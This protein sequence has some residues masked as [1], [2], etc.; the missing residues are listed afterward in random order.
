MAEILKKTIEINTGRHML[1]R[2]YGSPF[3]TDLDNGRRYGSLD[4][5]IKIVKLQND[6]ENID[7][8]SH[9]GCEANDVD[10]SIR[11]N[12]MTYNNLKYSDKPLMG[13]VLGYEAAK[14]SIEMAGIANGGIDVLKEKTVIA[15]IPCTL[16][17]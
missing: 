15:S 12:V 9:I 7:I 16:T 5:F 3:V 11:H 8:I 2:S 4:D 13:S 14:Q 6:L 1:C 10:A 17:P